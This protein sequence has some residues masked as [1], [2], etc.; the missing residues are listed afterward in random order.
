MTKSLLKS[1]KD[2]SATVGVI[3]LGYVGLPLVRAFVE[4]GFRTI[5]FDVDADKVRKLKAGQSYIKHLPSEWIATC[6]ADGRFEPTAEMRRLSEPDTL[7]MCVPTP[8]A[9]S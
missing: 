2:R 8:L 3:G 5:G 6:V 1:I 7:L 4:T 9:E